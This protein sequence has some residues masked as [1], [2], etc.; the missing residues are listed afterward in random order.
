MVTLSATVIWLLNP[1]RLLLHTA[2][3]ITALRQKVRQMG[4]LARSLSFS[5][6][7]VGCLPSSACVVF[8]FFFFGYPLGPAGNCF[9][10]YLEAII[11]FCERVCP[12]LE[13]ECLGFWFYDILAN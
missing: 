2:P 5:P 3:V 6:I 8:L 12:V 11:A 9:I 13:A 4:H 10:F 1:V 7:T